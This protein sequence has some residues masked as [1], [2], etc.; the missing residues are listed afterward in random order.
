M[1]CDIFTDIPQKKHEYKKFYEQLGMCVNFGIH[2]DSTKRTK[3]AQSLRFNT[4]K[5]GYER[6]LPHNR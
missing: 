2:E 1:P 3:I 6:H 4:S 5:S